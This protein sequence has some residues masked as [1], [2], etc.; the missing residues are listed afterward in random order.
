MGIAQGKTRLKN[1]CTW[2]IAEVINLI[3]HVCQEVQLQWNCHCAVVLSSTDHMWASGYFRQEFHEFELLDD[4]TKLRYKG[5]LPDHIQEN[6]ETHW[7]ERIR[8]GRYR[9][10]ASIHSPSFAMVCQEPL[11]FLPVVTDAPWQSWT[12]KKRKVPGSKTAAEVETT[13]IQLGFVAAKAVFLSIQGGKTK[14]RR[15]WNLN[16]LI[17]QRQKI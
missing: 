1:Q 3:I 17:K 10:C 2:A 15:S 12:R 6:S 5:K 4:I 16:A 7:S 14:T 9:V 8:N 11:P 13:N